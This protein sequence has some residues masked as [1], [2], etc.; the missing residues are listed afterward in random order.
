MHEMKLLNE[1]NAV[2]EFKWE[3]AREKVLVQSHD[4]A[5]SIQQSKIAS[6]VQAIEA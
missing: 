2:A 4:E 5:I 6:L 1:I 3:D